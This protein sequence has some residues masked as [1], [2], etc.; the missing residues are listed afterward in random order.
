MQTFLP[1]Q[2]FTASASCLDSRRLNKQI[3]EACQI[4]GILSEDYHQEIFE[5]ARKQSN[6]WK[7]HPA[8]LMW[9]G[10][11]SALIQYTRICCDEWSRRGH[12]HKLS[13]NV[14]YLSVLTQDPA[15]NPWWV[16]LDEFHLS[17]QSNLT[18]KDPEHYGRYWSVSPDLPYLWPTKISQK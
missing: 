8:V 10:H 14:L 1:Y 4:I 6:A 18:R 12:T 7:H 9:R 2:D 17:H 15:V 3:L 5:S 11:E 16:G 13:N